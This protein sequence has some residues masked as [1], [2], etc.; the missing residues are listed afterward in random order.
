MSSERLKHRRMVSARHLRTRPHTSA[1]P[2]G[3]LRE[4]WVSQTA[5]R[6]VG[7][8]QVRRLVFTGTPIHPPARSPTPRS[9]RTLLF[10][11][12]RPVT[13][14]SPLHQRGLSATAPRLTPT[15]R[16]MADEL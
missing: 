15:N 5:R 4:A 11:L 8:V 9:T 7:G 13:F 12:L 2:P 3:T 16:S 6:G 10:V 1:A 14:R